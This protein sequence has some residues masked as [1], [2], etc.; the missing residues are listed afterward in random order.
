MKFKCKICG[1]IFEDERRY[2]NHMTVHER[3]SKVFGYGEKDF[4][5]EYTGSLSPG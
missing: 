1:N 2:R 4:D 3:K 5:H